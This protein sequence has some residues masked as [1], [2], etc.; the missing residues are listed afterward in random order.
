MPWRCNR[1]EFFSCCVFVVDLATNLKQVSH[2]CSRP[3]NE[4]YSGIRKYLFWRKI[5][6]FW[7]RF[8]QLLRNVASFLPVSAPRQESS[9]QLPA[10]TRRAP[11]GW[12]FW[13][14]VNAF[15][16]ADDLLIHSYD[17]ELISQSSGNGAAG[18]ISHFL[19]NRK[20]VHGIFAV[21][22]INLHC[23]STWL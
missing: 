11:N 23:H 18:C 5:H 3:R 14:S 19:P 22:L 12:L 13:C 2:L 15:F 16:L 6:E 1:I 20:I 8:S 21:S 17:Q 9:V 10:A 7:S 4:P